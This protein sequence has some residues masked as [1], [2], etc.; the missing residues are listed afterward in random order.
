[1]T[2]FDNISL[3][4]LADSDDMGGFFQCLAEFPFI[5]LYINGMVELGV[6]QENQIVNGNHTGD[7]AGLD[8]YGEFTRQTMVELNTIAL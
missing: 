4:A 1:M 8:A 7:A 6:A 2:I 3:G 5:Q